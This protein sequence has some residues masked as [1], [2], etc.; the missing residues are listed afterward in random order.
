M[1]RLRWAVLAGLLM[2]CAASTAEAQYRTGRVWVIGSGIAFP[3]GPDAFSDLWKS[4]FVLNVGLHHSLN[5]EQRVL[6]RVLASYHRLSA[7][8]MPY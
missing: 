8:S 6:V 1:N 4:G 7:N 5:V 3:M 2:L